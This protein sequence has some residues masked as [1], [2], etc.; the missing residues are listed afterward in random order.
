MEWFRR[1]VGMEWSRESSGVGGG[2]TLVGLLGAGKIG[3][4]REEVQRTES[5]WI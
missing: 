4:I 3:E 2:E 1:S 5:A